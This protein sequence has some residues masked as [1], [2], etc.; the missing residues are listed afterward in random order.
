M[1]RTILFRIDLLAA[2]GELGDGSGVEI[3]DRMQ[4]TPY[5][6][7]TV[8]Q[9][10]L[11]RNLADLYEEG[12]IEKEGAVGTEKSYSLTAEGREV[13][14]QRKAIIDGA[15]LETMYVRFITEDG[16]YWEYNDVVEMNRVPPE[17]GLGDH[18]GDEPHLPDLPMELKLSDGSIE[19][20]PN[21]MTLDKVFAASVEVVDE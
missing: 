8:Q 14:E 16:D 15:L 2:I 18:P 4:E 13:L 10:R 6:R 17:R 1:D 21:D 20:V 9:T 5:R 11:Y 19:R 7:E 12:L 3:Q